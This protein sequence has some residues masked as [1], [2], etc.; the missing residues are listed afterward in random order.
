MENC[1]PIC[2][3]HNLT[4]EDDFVTDVELLD[5]MHYLVVATNLGRVLVYK[6]DRKSKEKHFMHEFKNHTKPIT[7]IH[8]MLVNP[9]YIVTASLDGT[10]K[11]WCLEMMI[12]L[13]SFEVG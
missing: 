10:V 2:E 12:E 5:H 4:G 3:Y 13:Y 9:T 7:C 1:K 6:W 11:V 8:P